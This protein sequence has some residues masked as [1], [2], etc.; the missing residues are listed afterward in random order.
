MLSQ[1]HSK[2]S[3]KTAIESYKPL[4][5][6]SRTNAQT[7]KRETVKKVKRNNIHIFFPTLR[8]MAC[9]QIAMDRYKWKTCYTKLKCEKLKMFLARNCFKTRD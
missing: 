6:S 3:E 2:T 5:H 8:D 9:S 1:A 4:L 7:T